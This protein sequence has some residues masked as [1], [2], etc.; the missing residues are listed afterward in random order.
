MGG[1]DLAR[2]DRLQKCE[3]VIE[4][5]FQL[6]KSRSFMKALGRDGEI[7]QVAN[8]LNMHLQD[9]LNKTKAELD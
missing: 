1:V 7:K 3:S 2:E 6:S 8:Q 5:F 4:A 9:F